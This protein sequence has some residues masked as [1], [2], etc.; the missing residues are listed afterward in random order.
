MRWNSSSTLARTVHP[1]KFWWIHHDIA[2]WL[3][4]SQ[5]SYMDYHYPCKQPRHRVLEIQRT[6]PEWDTYD[7][8]NLNPISTH[9][10]TMMLK[11]RQLKRYMIPHHFCILQHLHLVEPSLSS[12]VLDS[13]SSSVLS[14]DRKHTH[15]SQRLDL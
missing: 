6:I 7:R 8:Y 1:A 5:L 15:L 11:A 10:D 4:L 12:V 9:L 13:L 14:H 3:N 2:A